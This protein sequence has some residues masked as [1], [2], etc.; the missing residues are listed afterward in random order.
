MKTQSLAIIAALAM[1]PSFAAECTWNDPWLT[2]P[3]PDTV[4]GALR[5][6]NTY[7]YSKVEDVTGKPLAFRFWMIGEFHSYPTQYL[8]ERDYSWRRYYEVNC[9]EKTTTM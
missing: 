6:S 4:N 1:Q 9:A 8:Q 2:C 7:K 5:S 3:Q